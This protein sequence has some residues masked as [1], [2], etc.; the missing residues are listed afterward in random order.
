MIFT[1][2]RS[3]EGEDES[4]GKGDRRKRSGAKELWE[5]PRGEAIAVEGS[6]PVLCSSLC[7]VACVS[8]LISDCFQVGRYSL[9]LG[10]SPR[11]PFSLRSLA[12]SRTSSAVRVGPSGGEGTLV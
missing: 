8:W 7:G 11:T 4:P 10:G 12:G 3:M 5:P 2:C 1:T 9:H 6:S